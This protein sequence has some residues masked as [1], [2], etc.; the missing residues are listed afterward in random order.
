MGL[1]SK[2]REA[3]GP[4]QELVGFDTPREGCVGLV[5]QIAAP[6]VMAGPGKYWGQK[7]PYAQGPAHPQHPACGRDCLKSR[8]KH[9]SQQILRYRN[10]FI[11]PVGWK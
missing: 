4:E 2:P 1:P 9:Q 8:C 7:P 5:G 3:G 6:Q 11:S 10:A